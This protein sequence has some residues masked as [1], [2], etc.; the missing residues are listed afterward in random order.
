MPKVNCNGIL[1]YY[2]TIGSG[3][4]V[5]LI[6]GTGGNSQN[7]MAT[8]NACRGNYQYILPHNR[9]TGNSDWPE[10]PYRVSDMACDMAELLDTLG[11]QKAHVVGKSLGS[12][13]A[14]EMA[15]RF[16]YHVHTL[17]LLTTWD[18]TRKYLHLRRR[19]E[20]CVAL[21][22]RNELELYADFSMLTL[23][24]PGFVNINP[25]LVEQRKQATLSGLTGDRIQS[26]I[27]TYKADLAHDA[28]GRLNQI[29][30]PT[31]I[32]AGEQDVITLLDYNKS[33]QKQIQGAELVVLKE[34]GHAL[35][36]EAPEVLGQT[37]SRF[38]AAHPL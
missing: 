15:I 7:L 38:L 4:P 27:D 36:L 24:S 12:A 3:E 14:Q 10:G 29:Q 19:F 30:A 34:A 37:I 5:L 22:E 20:L 28:S 1:I 35:T 17:H 31:L 33:V 25:E 13:I 32:V 23:Y 6:T 21:L 11:I 8:L 2:D 18:S 16:S 26:L 9:G